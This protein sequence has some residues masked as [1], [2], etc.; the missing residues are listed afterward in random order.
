MF[1]L[2]VTES[3]GAIVVTIAA[4][5]ALGKA[6]VGFYRWT[7]RMEEMSTWITGQ[8]QNNGGT[9]ARDAIDRTE[10]KVDALEER[11]ARIESHLKT[12]ED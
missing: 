5:T 12:Q 2:D 6:G 8:M 3:A 9:S 7:R 4:I 11:I 1:G 10:R